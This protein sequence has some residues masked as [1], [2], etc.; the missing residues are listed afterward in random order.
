MKRVL[1]SALLCLACATPALADA[2]RPLWYGAMDVG[3][4][5]MQNTSY[6]NPGSLT[7][8][9]GYRFSRHLAAERGLNAIGDSTRTN[10]NGNGTRTARQGDMRFLAVVYLPLS[11]KLEL[12]GKAGLGLHSARILGTGGYSSSP[13]P[14]PTGNLIVGVGVQLNFN[15]CFG[16]RLQYEA[17]GQ[18][19]AS[20]SDPGAVISRLSIGGVLN[21]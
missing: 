18:S 11:Q 3:T 14:Y 2:D 7:F 15:Q 8:S 21:F 4:L 13:S 20:A 6:A 17:L 12:F 1:G 5:N 19:K 10:G 9:A 16:T